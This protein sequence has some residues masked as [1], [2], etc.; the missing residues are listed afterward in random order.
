MP[1][2]DAFKTAAIIGGCT[3]CWKLLKDKSQSIA[4]EIVV[5]AVCLGCGLGGIS[6]GGRHINNARKI[7]A[8]RRIENGRL[9]PVTELRIQNNHRKP[10]ARIKTPG[11]NVAFI[12]VGPK[13]RGNVRNSTRI[14]SRAVSLSKFS[15][16][17]GNSEV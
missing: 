13:S 7:I 10:M 16:R 15:E 6:G 5:A 14:S 8:Q 1:V 4:Q 3:F 12:S 9:A 17:I 11:Q 2:N